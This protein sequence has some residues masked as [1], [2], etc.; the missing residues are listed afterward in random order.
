[1]VTTYLSATNSGFLP[2]QPTVTLPAA[3]PAS[4]IAFIVLHATSN[5][6]IL[7]GFTGWTVLDGPRQAGNGVAQGWLLT[8]TVGASDSSTVASGILDVGTPRWSIEVIVVTDATRDSVTYFADNTA[9]LSMTV[10]AFTPVADNCNVLVLAGATVTSLSGHMAI[11]PPA[12][13]TELVDAGTTYGTSVETNVYAAKKTLSGQAGSLQAAVSAVTDKT[14]RAN[15]WI[16]ALKPSGTPPSVSSVHVGS[17]FAAT[18]SIATSATLAMPTHV[19]GDVA[20]LT[21]VYNPAVVTLG[22]LAGW[23]ALAPYVFSASMQVQVYTRVLDGTESSVI[24]T[25]TPASKVAWGL[26]IWRG[27]TYAG[28]AYTNG[29][30][31]SATVATPGVATPTGPAVFTSVWLERSSTPDTSVAFSGGISDGA[32]FGLAGGACSVAIAH[33]ATADSDGTTGSGTWTRGSIA[34]GGVCAVTIAFYSTGTSTPTTTATR[35]R[36]IGGVWVAQVTSI[37]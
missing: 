27:V 36:F 24:P 18:N 5:T 23:T 13:Y 32:A 34:T 33:N 31:T 10:P 1:M 17:A 37:L 28:V 29:V 2:T 35:Y 20:T 26:D 16:V 11:T 4:S 22:A 3:I 12:G 15:V 6:D 9:D 25:W 21:A 7:T 8:K 30:D 19:A 14:H